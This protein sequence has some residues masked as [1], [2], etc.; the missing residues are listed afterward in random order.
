MDS[1]HV[2]Q[3]AG[4]LLDSIGPRLTGS[5]N[6]RDAQDWLVVD[7]Q[8]LGDRREERAATAPGAAGVAAVAHRP[9]QP[10]RAH[11]RGARCSAFSPGTRGKPLVAGT[12]ILPHFDDSTEFVNWLPQAKGKLV[13][14]SAPPV[15]CRPPRT[16]RSTPR[17]SR[18]RAWTPCAPRA[19]ATG[20][21]AQRARHRATRSPSAAVSSALALE[22]AGVAGIL[23]LAPQGRARHARDLRDLQHARADRLAQLR[24]LRPRL[25]PH[26][27]RQQPAASARP[28]VAV[29]RRAAGVQHHRHDPRHREAERVRPPLGALRFVGRLVR[30]DRQR[31]RHADDDGSDA[32]P[33]A[34]V[35]ASE[36]HDSRRPLDRRGDRARRLEGVSRGSSRGARRDCRPCSTTTTAPAASCA[37]ARRDS[38]TATCTRASGCSKLPDVFRDQVKYI[39]VGVPGTGGS[40]DFSFYCAGAPSFGLG[41][42]NWNYGND[43]WHTDRD[44]YDKIVFDDLKANATL[45]AMMA[46]LASEDPDE[47][48][49]RADRP[50]RR[51]R[52][53]QRGQ[54]DAAAARAG[55]RAAH[56][57]A[58]DL[59]G[60]RHRSPQDQP[61]PAER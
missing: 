45:A 43:T 33:E 54:R 29:A 8:E 15:T 31:H 49:A 44:T 12:I 16:G 23:A 2:Q 55:R 6:V 60:V 37:W 34:G 35:S 1:S 50:R 18:A 52:L 53:D 13:L 5:P 14:V 24:G 58:H 41:G 17:R 26:R 4:T 20:A 11:A 38:R 51:R 56:P 10:A 25:P 39:G 40:D 57:A 59:A 28:R 21:T 61:A 22:E 47:D 9:H 48:H 46:Y 3:L 30:R 32:H 7:V 19:R 27:A 36:A 42:L